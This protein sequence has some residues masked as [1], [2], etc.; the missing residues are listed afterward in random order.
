MV[1]QKKNKRYHNLCMILSPLKIIIIFRH[2]P[3]IQQAAVDGKL[4]Q[5]ECTLSSSTKNKHVYIEIW[6]SL[7]IVSI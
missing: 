7:S 2:S 5:S 3:T 6:R 1:N 4:G